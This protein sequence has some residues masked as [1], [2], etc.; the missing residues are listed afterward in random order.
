MP[1][2]PTS[3][4][5]F[6]TPK[7]VPFYDGELASL[8][9]EKKRE[10]IERIVKTRINRHCP[11]FFSE[12]KVYGKDTKFRV[13]LSNLNEFPKAYGHLNVFKVTRVLASLFMDVVDC[14]D[15]VREIF[16]FG[17]RRIY[18]DLEEKGD[19]KCWF[20]ATISLE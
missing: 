3:S 19:V 8:V 12:T 20:N 11:N 18:I 1:L 6:F 5:E 16:A 7:T 2:I 15:E 9:S 10:E 14:S 4:P 17:Y 13:E